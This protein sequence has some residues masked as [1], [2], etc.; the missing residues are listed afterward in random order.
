MIG[1][2]MGNETGKKSSEHSESYQA[3]DHRG[4]HIFPYAQSWGTVPPPPPPAILPTG[5][6]TWAVY[7]LTSESPYLGAAGV[8]PSTLSGKGAPRYIGRYQ[9]F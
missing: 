7:T 3:S 5:R 1:W 2:E 8:R 9:Q 6:G 4:D